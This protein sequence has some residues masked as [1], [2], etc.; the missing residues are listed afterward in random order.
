[1]STLYHFRMQIA[2]CFN[3]NSQKKNVPANNCHPKVD[4]CCARLCIH[5][6]ASNDQAT[7]CH[8][9]TVVHDRYKCSYACHNMV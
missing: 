1:M 2:A 6:I 4:T 5:N 7:Q 8:A 3:L 9:L